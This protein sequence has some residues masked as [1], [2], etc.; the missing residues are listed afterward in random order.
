ML[1]I[2]KR[3]F[4]MF[5][6]ALLFVITITSFLLNYSHNTVMVAWDPKQLVYQF[7]EQFR[8]LMKYSRRPC[9]CHTC[10]SEEGVSLWFDDRFNQTMQPFLTTQ[11]A[12]M[13]E[14][15][16]RWWLKL[17][18]EKNP[19]GLNE[20]IQELFELI[21]GDADQLLERSGSRCRR[22][23]VVGNSGNLKQ[24]QYGQEIDNHDF[25]FRMNKAPTAGYESDV[26]S[27]TTHHFVY[28]ES[29]KEL[30]ENVSMIVIPFK[31]LDLRWVV[32]ALT[33][34]TINHTY[35][36]VPRKIKVN[37]GKI[38]IYHPF[39]IK[40]V[41]DNWLHHHGR[42][43]STGFLS[44]I[45]ALHICDEVDIYGFG[46]DSKGNWHHYW[47]NNPS[48]GAFR[49]TGVHDGDFESNVTLTLAS[50]DKVRFFKGR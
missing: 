14:D 12:F 46:A 40:Y 3:G 18:G 32:S 25:V 44:V 41:Y 30:S 13:P 27:K 19:K 33:T 8:R 36:P 49:Q 31:T 45:F 7:S 50:V 24:S 47:E 6:L 16:Y 4:K 23:A 17:Q 48:A 34:G 20:T 29:Y 21:P 42:Y 26:G 38:L 35:I 15:S 5:T 1:A 39:F 43:P 11:N 37:K 2:R 22:C 9:S 10:I 28:P